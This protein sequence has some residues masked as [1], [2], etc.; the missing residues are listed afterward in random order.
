MDINMDK[1]RIRRQIENLRE[2][3]K[4]H[5]DRYYN[6]DDPEISD[7][8]YD[9]LA[10]EL[11]LLEAKYPEFESSDSPVRKVGGKVKRELRKV[12]HDV[13]VISLQDGFSKEDIQDFYFRVLEETDSP[14]FVVEKKIDGLS[15]V[16]RY[17][18]GEL[19]EAITRGD[20]AVGESVYEN[21][22]EILSIPKV[23]KERLPYVEVRG[24]VYMTKENFEK[25]NRI[26]AQTGGKLYQNERNT[27]AGTLRQLDSR[28]V[29]ERGLD[30][31]VFNLEICQGKTFETH[32][33]TLQWMESQ[34]F[35]VSPEYRLCRNFPEIWQ[36]V[37]EIEKERW[38]L[39]YGI[40]GAVIKADNLA[41]RK[42]LGM[43][44][45]VPRWAVAYKYPP[46]EQ[47]TILKDISVQVGRTGRITPLAILEPIRI[48]G[49]TV[50]KATLHNQDYIDLKDIRIG[51]T[52]VVRKAGD[53]IPEVLRVIPKKR[54]A[55]TTRYILPETCPICGAKTVR[56]ANGA[57]LRCSGSDCYGKQL[58]AIEYFVSKD[59][60]DINGFGPGTV[61]TLYRNGF[62]ESI[63]DLYELK[64][65][66]AELIG[67]GVVGREK[68]V[69]RLLAAIEESKEK[70]LSC[71][72]TGL[73]IRNIGKE[74]A[75]I[76]AAH[77]R[78]IDEIMAADSDAIRELSDFGEVAAVEI[79]GFFDK[80]ENRALIERLRSLGVKMDADSKSDRNDAR[81]GGMTFVLTGTLPGLT[82]NE[83]S[84]IIQSFGG[85][86]SG[87]V[88]RKTTYVLAGSAPGSKLTKAQ[89]LGIPI[90][91]QE[92]LEKM[93]S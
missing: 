13:P 93:V 64:Y 57:D 33:E 70:G 31:F 49:T 84:T 51:D 71:L 78:D 39:P 83:A 6:Q 1:E 19:K 72:L 80:A 16:L 14:A 38:S 47:E 10:R 76:L 69:D 24:E 85:K 61:E 55:G 87:S 8:E 34:G 59:A 67:S 15:V 68:N 75:R 44:S 21:C 56:E 9:I 43:T 66:R 25:T 12:E 88:S 36:A 81:L 58:R 74:S 29:R 46:E 92:D 73:G 42:A 7:H 53:I 35:P 5:N 48:A 45:R 37:E 3:I 65:R 23:L 82:R 62:V 28:I 30:I 41:D 18:N 63:A 4:Y 20:G 60:M 89:A 79:T 32:S 2:E 52:V 77:F 17:Y 86:V 90:I 27:A 22:L 54:P 91:S 26:Q 50:S 40:D 11:R